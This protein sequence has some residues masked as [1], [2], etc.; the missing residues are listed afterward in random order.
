MVIL[1]K[2]DAYAKGIQQ[3]FKTEFERYGGEVLDLI[4]FP[5]LR[6]R[7]FRVWWSG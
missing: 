2:E 7:S 6:F 1:A 5:S 4:E 3:V